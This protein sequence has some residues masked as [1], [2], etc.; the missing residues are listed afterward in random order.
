MIP[1]ITISLIIMIFS[2]LITRYIPRYPLETISTSLIIGIILGNITKQHLID[3]FSKG[4]KFSEK[5]LLEFAIVLMGLKLNINYL[6]KLGPKALIFVIISIITTI[7]IS[8]II[9]RL[10][11][12]NK[13][14]SILT[15]VGNSICGSSAIAAF[16]PVL[17]VPLIQMSITIGVINFL[18]TIGIFITPLLAKLLQFSE[19][20]SSFLIGGTLQAVGHVA[21]AGYSLGESVGQN[22]IIIK[23][24]RVLMIGPIVLSYSIYKS[25]KEGG[26]LSIPKLPIF[27]LGFVIASLITTF[28][29]QH[30]IIHYLLFL[31][32]VLLATA[33]AAIGFNISFTIL[34]NKGASLLYTG[35]SLFILQILL[36]IGLI[37]LLQI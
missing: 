27:L 3:K 23:M 25:S 16:N 26:K 34:K 36:A 8:P 24:F 29:G 14:E 6:F 12:L 30:I 2:F 10:F 18:G 21:A 28:V 35:G 11:K 9:G 37:Y 7:S 5:H 17:G 13:N 1:G 22:A 31:S 4:L 19:I 32:K 15:G 20:Q 33:M